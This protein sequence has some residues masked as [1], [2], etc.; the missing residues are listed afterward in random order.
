MVLLTISGLDW[1]LS[2]RMTLVISSRTKSISAADTMRCQLDA[3]CYGSFENSPSLLI[4]IADMA[5]SS[6]QG[7]RIS[8]GSHGVRGLL[9]SRPPVPYREGPLAYEPVVCVY[10]QQKGTTV[11]FVE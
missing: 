7:S 4:S 8:A 6:S 5:A 2:F 9:R 3:F 11:D 10:V 1:L